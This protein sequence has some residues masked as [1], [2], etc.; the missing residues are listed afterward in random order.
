MLFRSLRRRA[1]ERW[2]AAQLLEHPFLAFAGCGGD[3]EAKWASP[4][5]TLDAAMWESDADE[6]DMVPGDCTADRMKALAAFSSVMPDFESD[7]GWIDVLSGQS[8]LPDEQSNIEDSPAAALVE[9][10]PTSDAFLGMMKSI[11]ARDRCRSTSRWCC[12][13]GGHGAV[14]REIGRA[15]V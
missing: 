8:E 11:G 9:D 12:R 13:T 2:T 7:D 5:S 4:K 15:H 10:E 3:V 6:D 14:R 1:G